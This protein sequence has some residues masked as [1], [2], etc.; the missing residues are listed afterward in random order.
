MSDQYAPRYAAPRLDSTDDLI[1]L[2]LTALRTA[3]EGGEFE[4]AEGAKVTAFLERYDSD[5]ANG[6]DRRDA[7]KAASAA[8]GLRVNI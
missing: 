2:S 6:V 4:G 1:G 5:I 8:S 7:I 3:H